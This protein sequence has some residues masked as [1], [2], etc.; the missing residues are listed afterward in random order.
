MSR[1]GTLPYILDI[2]NI[3]FFFHDIQIELRNGGY[4]KARA[5]SFFKIRINKFQSIHEKVSHGGWL[6]E[7]RSISTQIWMYILKFGS[8]K[9]RRCKFGNK[10]S[11]LVQ[12]EWKLHHLRLTHFHKSSPVNDNEKLLPKTWKRYHIFPYV[13]CYSNDACIV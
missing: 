3:S 11:N 8:K 4:S 5:Y 1:L 6:S 13:I 2:H 12:R 7:G 10:Y 9:L